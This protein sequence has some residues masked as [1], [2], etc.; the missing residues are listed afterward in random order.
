MR[1]GEEG[2]EGDER[3]LETVYSF[4]IAWLE[5]VEKGRHEML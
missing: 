4:M 5:N 2:D 3:V 1:Q